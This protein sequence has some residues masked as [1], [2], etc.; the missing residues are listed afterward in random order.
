MKKLL[1]LLI[2][3]LLFSCKKNSNKAKPVEE[4]KVLIDELINKGDWDIRDSQMGDY[5][6]GPSSRIP[7]AYY[8]SELFS[9][10]AF[11][12]EDGEI[13]IEGRFK[14]GKKEG[15]WYYNWNIVGH[16]V[17]YKNG[18]IHGSWNNYNDAFRGKDSLKVYVSSPVRNLGFL[19]GKLMYNNGEFLGGISYLPNG[20]KTTCF[21]NRMQKITCE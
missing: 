3:P 9:G 7:I 10:I 12:I 13:I 2:I 11:D 18:Q 15:L 17:S 14:N 5:G 1:I 4:K 20:E 8:E 6:S 19:I 21:D 16:T